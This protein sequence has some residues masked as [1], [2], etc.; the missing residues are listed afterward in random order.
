MLRIG[1]PASIV[2]IERSVS[3]VLLIGFVTPFGD[4]ALA[5]Y[6]VTRRMETFASWGSNGVA[7]GTGTMV[8]QNL[9][10]GKPERSRSAVKWGLVYSA[11]AGL[12][13]CIAFFSFPAAF[14]SLFTDNP[15]VT[16][17]GGDWLRVQ[18]FAFLFLGTSAIFAQSFNT[19]GDT[20]PAMLVTLL[21]VWCV[22]I[23]LSWFFTHETD[24]GVLGIGYAAV[25]AMGL[26]I[27]C[28]V[29]YFMTDRW[30][31]KKVL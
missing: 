28:Y 8:G 15:D 3:Q 16:G 11:S 18:A 23:P 26:R 31:R 25:A 22:E 9:G 4:A 24:L 5:A 12:I 21:S 13:M 29:P 17:L 19:A 14:V 30:M 10:A 27:A 2:G 1:L 20:V 7:Q 6:A